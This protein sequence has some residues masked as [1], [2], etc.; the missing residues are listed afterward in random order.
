MNSMTGCVLYTFI[1]SKVQQFNKHKIWQNIGATYIQICQFV[2]FDPI[3]KLNAS[4]CSKN[5][6]V[7][8]PM[9]A[10]SK[11]RTIFYRSNTGIVSSNLA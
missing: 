9:A 4:F 3:H 1:V 6:F 10:Q 5:K 2:R 11:A 8:V 7:P